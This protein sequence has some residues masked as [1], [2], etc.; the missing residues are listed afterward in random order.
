MLYLQC[1]A[2]H[3]R[4]LVDVKGNVSKKCLNVNCNIEASMADVR[5]DFYFVCFRKKIEDIPSHQL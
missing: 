5:I 1:M 4:H 2:N 3:Y